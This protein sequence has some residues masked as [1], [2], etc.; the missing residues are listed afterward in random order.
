MYS[1]FKKKDLIIK[2]M[3]SFCNYYRVIFSN[4]SYLKWMF[5][6]PADLVTKIGLKHMLQA[7]VMRLSS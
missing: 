6:H 7:G 3:I 5:F 2:L 1:L 4:I